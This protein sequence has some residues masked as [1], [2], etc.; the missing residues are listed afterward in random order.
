MSSTRA[1]WDGARVFVTG[2][3][4]FVGTN[5]IR[6]LAH[7]G[8]TCTSLDLAEPPA[9]LPV[10]R[11]AIGSADDSELLRDFIAEADVVFA[12]AGRSGAVDSMSSIEQD[13]QT[14]C[15]AQIRL[16]ECVRD[17]NP[18]AHVVFPGSRLEYGRAVRLPIDEEH[19]IAPLSPYALHK[20]TAGQYHMVYHRH[21]GV[22]STVL[23]LS[24]PYGPHA[25]GSRTG[26]YSVLNRFIDTAI[27]DGAI[28][29]FGE[30]SQVRDYIYVQDV[31]E[32]LAAA[33][34]SDAAVGQVLNIGSGVP[35]SIAE[36]AQT[37]VDVVGSGRIE[38]M[39]WPADYAEVETGDS[40]FCIDRARTLLDWEPTTDLACGI[41]MCIAGQDR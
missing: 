18:G 3:S 11:S 13:L 17:L 41:R 5:L 8:A 36:A 12:L 38:H 28:T 33:A 29:L 25:D 26:Y 16:L 35:T 14:N 7:L 1:G 6:H 4:G 10:A 23:R 19:P 37:V 9:G 40:Y 27:A 2:G 31:V 24:N 32:A 22:R 21:Y 20:F 34:T 30:G 39:P 15:V